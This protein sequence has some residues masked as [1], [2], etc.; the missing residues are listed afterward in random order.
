MATPLFQ[1]SGCS[2][3]RTGQY[4]AFDKEP[5]EENSLARFGSDGR[6]GPTNFRICGQTTRQQG[7]LSSAHPYR[8]NT[9]CRWL[10]KVTLERTTFF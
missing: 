6:N 7:F 8:P 1:P 2:A 10:I 9:A 5:E 4:L 3:L